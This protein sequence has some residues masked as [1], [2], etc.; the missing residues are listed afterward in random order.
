MPKTSA[1]IAKSEQ[2]AFTQDYSI[3]KHYA[4][5]SRCPWLRYST[6]A[7]SVANSVGETVLNNWKLLQNYIDFKK[8]H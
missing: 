7:T 8:L 4:T 2:L 5:V 6:N 3:S 1:G